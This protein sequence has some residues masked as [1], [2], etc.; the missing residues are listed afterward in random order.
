M[1]KIIYTSFI[2]LLSFFISSWCFCFDYKVYAKSENPKLCIIIDDFGSYDQSGVETMLSID[3]P[4]TCAVMPNVDNTKLNSEQIINA[5]KEVIIHMPMQACVNIPQSW[6]GPTYIGSS[7]TKND[8]Y[9]KLDDAYKNIPMAKGFNM[10]IGS[11]VCQNKNV[12]GYVYDYAKEKNQFFIDSRT[13]INTTC[14]KV[15]KEK[16]IIYLGR[17]EFLEPDHNR[18][19]DSVKKHLLIGAN[20]AKEKGYAIVIGH[21]GAHGGENTAKAIKDTISDIKDMKVDIVFASELYEFL[22][23]NKS[24]T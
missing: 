21:V 17:D 7:D 5:N 22:T 24:T 11:G 23:K 14:D 10:H 16:N 4:I 19:Y 1:K 2:I 8:V 9:K 18:S 20:L 12:M 6:Y 15:A 13:H 3:A